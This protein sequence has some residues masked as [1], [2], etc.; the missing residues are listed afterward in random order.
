VYSG[1]FPVLTPSLSAFRSSLWPKQ[2]SLATA[3]FCTFFRAQKCP[4]LKF[5][6]L[7]IHCLPFMSPAHALLKQASR[8]AS[9]QH[10]SL[11]QGIDTFQAALPFVHLQTFRH[12][13]IGIMS[14]ECM[15]CMFWCGFQ[16]SKKISV[17][18]PNWPDNSN[19]NNTSIIPCRPTGASCSCNTVQPLCLWVVLFSAAVVCRGGEEGLRAKPYHG[20]TTT[21]AAPNIEL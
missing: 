18:W 11:L 7:K 8:I 6:S 13:V 19:D 17:T 14:L 16:I 21:V 2:G 1:I 10:P 4:K 12:H 3:L 15:E 5:I 20:S 9:K